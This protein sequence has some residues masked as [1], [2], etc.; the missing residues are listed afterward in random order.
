MDNLHCLFSPIMGFTSS[1]P[2]M[3]TRKVDSATFMSYNS[4]GIDNPI[5]CK[6]INSICDEYDVDFL[7]IQEHFKSSKT[8]DKYFRQ[9]FPSYDSVTVPAHRAHGQESGRA[10]AGLGQLCKK[11]LALKSHRVASNNFRVQAQV[12]QLP[13]TTILWINSYLPTDPQLMRNYDDSELQGCLAEVD[14]I[15]TNTQHDNIVWASDLNWDLTRNTMFAQTVSR[16]MDRFN[17]VSL[18]IYHRVSHTYEQVLRNGQVSQSTIDHII[19]SPRLLSHVLDCGVVHRGDNLSSHSPIWVKLKV[20]ALPL[21]QTAITRPQIKPSWSQATKE[22]VD[23]YTAAL[24]DKLL[25]VKVPGSLLCQDVSCQDRCH[26]EDRDSLTLDILCALVETSY[27]VLSL[28]IHGVNR[29]NSSRVPG[30]TEEVRPYQAESRYWH[31]VWVQEGRPRGTWLHGLMVRKRSQYH[32][33]IRR[34]RGRADLTRAEHLFEAS[35]QG[36]CN[37]L[38]EMKK[39]RC[40]G[41]SNQSELPD[42]VGG[43]SGEDEIVQK[44]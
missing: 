33:A 2:L 5:K 27:T 7:N 39:I 4:T 18:W 36:D 3:T 30:W 14:N 32:Y 41:C 6:W 26:V 20:G 25:H 19:I 29:I 24:Y 40:G 9:K 21:K 10:K 13:T 37:L 34:A 42:T 12:L 17:L 43:V 16:F 15:I 31:D 38:A 1:P 22:H 8:T 35:L 28:Y 44:F 23:D 11:N